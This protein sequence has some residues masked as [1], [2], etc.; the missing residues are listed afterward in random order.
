[1]QRKEISPSVDA[2]LHPGGM[3]NLVE[4]VTQIG[5]I[6]QGSGRP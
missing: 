5:A 3:G 6:G 2:H 4:L 1:L